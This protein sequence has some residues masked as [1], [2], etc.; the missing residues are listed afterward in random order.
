MDRMD[1][2]ESKVELRGWWFKGFGVWAV[3][4]GQVC[5][6]RGGGGGVRS[7][8]KVDTVQCDTIM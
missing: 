4:W 7:G 3:I 8:G 6:G 2:I 5:G 1:F